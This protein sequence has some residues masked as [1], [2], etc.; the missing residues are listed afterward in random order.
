MPVQYSS[1]NSL[2]PIVPNDSLCNYSICYSHSDTIKMENID[3][4]SVTIRFEHPTCRFYQLP[5]REID[6]I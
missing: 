6:L 4:T 1:W 3:I 5:F 2:V